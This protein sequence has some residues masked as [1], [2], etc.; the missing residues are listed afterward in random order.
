MI[1]SLG[2]EAVH[3]ITTLELPSQVN[4][5]VQNSL[6]GA[7]AIREPADGRDLDSRRSTNDSLL[8]SIILCTGIYV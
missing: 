3:L 8:L 2:S 4:H 6:G 1:T 5:A 7:R